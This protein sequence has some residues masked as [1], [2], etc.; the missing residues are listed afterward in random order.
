METIL[1][2]GQ[3]GKSTIIVDERFEEVTKY[4]PKKKHFIITDK[5]IEKYYATVF[6]EAPFFSINPGEQSK[7]LGGVALQKKL[8]KSADKRIIWQYLQKF[9]DYNSEQFNFLG[10]QPYIIGS[11][12][13]TA[14]TFR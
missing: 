11:D 1:I 4:L 10:V 5:N 6:Q 2:E 14:L 9:I 3:N 13:S 12:Q 8:F 7:Q